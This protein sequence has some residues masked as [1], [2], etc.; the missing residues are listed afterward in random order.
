[1]FLIHLMSTF[2]AVKMTNNGSFKKRYDKNEKAKTP[3]APFCRVFVEV[4][5]VLFFTGLFSMSLEFSPHVWKEYNSTLCQKSC[6][7]SARSSFL[8]QVK[9]KGWSSR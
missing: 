5:Q 4:S 7:F 6:V 8:P 9:L 3:Q 2:H 1:M